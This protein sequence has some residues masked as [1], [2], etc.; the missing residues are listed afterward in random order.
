LT[1]NITHLVCLRCNWA[2]WLN[3]EAVYSQ[4]DRSLEWIRTKQFLS[5]Y[6]FLFSFC[7]RGQLMSTRD[8]HSFFYECSIYRVCYFGL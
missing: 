1:G 2:A 5:C 4:T 7:V 3:K 6:I 8:S